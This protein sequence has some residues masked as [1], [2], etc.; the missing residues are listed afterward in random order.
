MSLRATGEGHISSIE[1]REG[2]LGADNAI[3]IEPTNR[4]VNAP[5]VLS[6]P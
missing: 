6:D 1:F 4:F 3:T 5:E 2:V